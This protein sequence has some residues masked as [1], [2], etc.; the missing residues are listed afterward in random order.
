MNRAQRPDP[1]LIYARTPAGDAERTARALDLEH[2]AR[3][4]LALVDARRSVGDLSQFARPGEL[5]PVLRALEQRKL[6]EV[7][8]LA[9]EPTEAERRERERREQ[10][11][12]QAAK[13]ALRNTFVAELGAAGRVWDA[14]VADSVSLEV[15]R[16]VLREAVDVVE[17]RRG[18]A[19]AQR[20]LSR[21]RP[22]FA[23][24]V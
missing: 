3:R 17:A 23:P 1:R 9:A 10:V 24:E 13:H 16:R 2:A 20:V 19:A 8:A 12:L 7:V 6:V 11:R 5:G 18:E 4:I 21:V 22:L 14:R 15:L